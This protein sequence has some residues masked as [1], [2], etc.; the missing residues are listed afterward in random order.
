MSEYQYYEFQALDRPL[1]KHEIAE[2]RALSTRATI[3]P[4]RFVNTYH[5]GDFRGDPRTLIERYFDAFLYVANWGTHELMLRLPQQQ[6]DTE[7]ASLYCACD[8][9]EASASGGN[10]IL[11]F[12]SEDEESEGW[13]EGEGWLSSLIPIRSDIASGDLRAL[14]LGWLL[15]VQTEQIDEESQEPPVPPGLGDLSAPL[16][17]LA[18]FLRI[19]PDLIEVAARRSPRA[20]P[21]APPAELARWV[22]ELPDAEK[23]E[24]LLRLVGGNDP[25]L[26]AELL[27]RFRRAANAAPVELPGG[28]RTV[29]QLLSEAEAHSEAKRRAVAEREAAERARREREQAA[30]R[31]R[32]LDGLL[33]RQEETWRRIEALI[34]TKRPSEYEQAVQLL[35]D[36]RDLAARKG[37]VDEF[38]ARLTRLRN[39]HA[40]K[41][42]LIQRLDRSR[43][44]TK[45]GASSS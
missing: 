41:P 30:A 26:Q 17:A 11:Q 42:S 29:A 8:W 20:V 36:L 18:D 6:L 32:Y 40:R 4:T 44:V 23:N 31:A 19:D 13:E 24:V 7:T 5:Y 35:R 10:V 25:Y 33:P 12:L 37:S 1:D 28:A 43:L 15:C 34:D 27:R 21:D 9:A 38:D 2:L 16:R 39:A 22:R 14:Y 3:T 45:P